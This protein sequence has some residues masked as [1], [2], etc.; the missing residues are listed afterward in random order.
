MSKRNPRRSIVDVCTE[1]VPYGQALISVHYCMLEC[2][3]KVEGYPNTLDGKKACPECGKETKYGK[4]Y[5]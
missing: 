4:A 2:G 1:C 5:H 3:H